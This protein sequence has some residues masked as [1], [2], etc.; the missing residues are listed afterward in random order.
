MPRPLEDDARRVGPWPEVSRDALV[1]AAGALAE[2]H[3]GVEAVY[4]FGSRARGK[5]RPGSDLD[6][7]VL[8]A[9][10]YPPGHP[11][12]VGRGRAPERL[13]LQQDLARFVEDW[14]GLPVDVVV[15][16]PDLPPGLLFD[17][18]RVETI[19]FAR[20]PDRAH[21]VACRARAEY[22]DLLPRLERQLARTRQRLKE[23]AD[24]LDPA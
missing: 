5:A 10:G 7:A 1:E 6:L 12:K 24:A 16:H 21:L 8:L 20:D 23:H 22:R 13:L 3:P 15:L 4:L 19:L 14:L 2:A 11:P 9:A 17:I 18:F